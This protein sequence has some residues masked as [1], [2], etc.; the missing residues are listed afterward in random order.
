MLN[1][2]HGV[3]GHPD[4]GHHHKE[5]GDDRD[6]LAKV[7][8]DTPP[9][10]SSHLGRHGGVGLLDEV[11]QADLVLDELP[12]PEVFLDLLCGGGWGLEDWS[13]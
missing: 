3:E 10:P 4:G 12:R 11:P 9:P 8:D 2:G 5:D 1:H 13:G 6:D 7:H